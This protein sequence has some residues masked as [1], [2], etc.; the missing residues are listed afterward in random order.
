MSSGGVPPGLCGAGSVEEKA[1]RGS[2]LSGLAELIKSCREQVFMLKLTRPGMARW[3]LAPAG[4]VRVAPEQL[5]RV[6]TGPPG[7]EPGHRSVPHSGIGSNGPRLDSFF[8]FPVSTVF[9]DGR[10][11]YFMLQLLPCESVGLIL[12][13]SSWS[14][15]MECVGCGAGKRVSYS[16]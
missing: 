15:R 14:Y 5:L 13:S 9:Y 3:L 16:G 7:V 11:V 2:P 6:A 1:T 8:F 10:K 12:V 4:G